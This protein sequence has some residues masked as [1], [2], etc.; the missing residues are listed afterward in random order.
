MGGEGWGEDEEGGGG[1]G[2]GGLHSGVVGEGGEGGGSC[3]SDRVIPTSM[4]F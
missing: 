4:A 1:D 2:A 3:V